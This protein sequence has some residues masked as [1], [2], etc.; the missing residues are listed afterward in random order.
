MKREVEELQRREEEESFLNRCL[1]IVI[2]AKGFGKVPEKKT[3]FILFFTFQFS[4]FLFLFLFSTFF[5][6]FFFAL[7]A[8]E[9]GRI[10]CR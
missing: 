10:A 9:W 2:K 8:G 3:L 6:F 1:V 5:F 4:L 7:E